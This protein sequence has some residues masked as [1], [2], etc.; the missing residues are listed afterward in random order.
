MSRR[1][2]PSSVSIICS[3]RS[4]SCWSFRW[5]LGIWR[6][7]GAPVG[8]ALE[9][10]NNRYAEL[11]TAHPSAGG[12]YHFLH[13]AYGRKVSFLFAWAR[14]AVITTGSIALL[15]FVG[16]VVLSKHLMRGDIAE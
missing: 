1:S 10:F 11:A 12:D 6:R 8:W 2:P 7:P 4:L 13:R 3:T 5:K 9:F 16:T 14:F 15:G